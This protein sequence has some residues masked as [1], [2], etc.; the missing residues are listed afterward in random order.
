MALP[1]V[2]AVGVSL[3]LDRRASDRTR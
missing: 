1:G 2:L 3:T